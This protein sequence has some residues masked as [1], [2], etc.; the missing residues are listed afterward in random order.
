MKIQFHIRGVNVNAG[1][2]RS[3][4]QPLEQLGNLISISVA[5]VVVEHQWDG[6]PAFRAYV[7]LAVPGPDIQAEA[8]DHTLK[9]AWLKV[10]VA[11]RQKIE[12]RKTRREARVK[13]NGH[14]RASAIRRARGVAK[15]RAGTGQHSGL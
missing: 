5:V 13:T 6:A 15:S 7:S 9:A 14:L 8:S 3:L 4:E 1:L 11:L 2:R 10:T 12:Q